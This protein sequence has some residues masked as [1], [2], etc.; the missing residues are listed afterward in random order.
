MVAIKDFEMPENCV[1]CYLTRG[2]HCSFTDKF[3][4]Y[5]TRRKDCPLVEIKEKSKH[6]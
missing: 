1:D 3:I 4:E 5:H 2:L 6:V